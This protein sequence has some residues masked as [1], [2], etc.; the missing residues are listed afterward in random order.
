M[1]LKLLRKL[2]FIEYAINT[3]FFS[4][5]FEVYLGGENLG[6]FKQLN[7]IIDAENPFGSNF[8]TSIVYAPV[9][10]RMLYAGLRFKLLNKKQ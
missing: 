4:S 6:D 10:G 3:S 8:D 7:P 5:Q 1:D 9:F 2:W